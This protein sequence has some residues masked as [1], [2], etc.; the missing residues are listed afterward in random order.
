MWLYILAFLAITI[1]LLNVSQTVKYHVKYIGYLLYC[2]FL[3]F[4]SGLFCL[5]YKPGTSKNVFI[6]QFII[7]LIQFEWLFGL[8]IKFKNL[9]Y[10]H[11]VT[12]PC[13]VVSNHQTSLDALLLLIASPIGTAPLAKRVLLYVPI[14]GPV[15]WL[16]GTIFIDRTK[17]KT[18]IEIMRKVGK[19]MKE[20]MTSLWIF[21]EGS[22]YQQDKILP[23]K[24][25]AFHLAIQAGVPIVPVVFG[26]YRNVIDRKNH[27]FDGGEIRTICLPPI[28][29]EGKTVDDVNELLESTHKLMSEAFDEDYKSHPEIYKDVVP[30]KHD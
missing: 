18:A 20:K 27:R 8:K 30:L 25:G 21:P 19:E 5:L 3:A 4:C 1:I 13:V 23:F 22:R 2:I 17:G 14:F 24:K 12:K 11:E 29:T 10:L 7:K 28:S 16:C 26:N 9:E 6:P 15:C